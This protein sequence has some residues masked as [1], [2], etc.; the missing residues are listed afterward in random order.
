MLYVTERCVV[1]LR[2]EGLTVVEVAPGVDVARDV[3]Q[4]AGFPLRVAGDLR[5][6][7]ARLFDPAPMGLALPPGRAHGSP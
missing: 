1:E 4:Q 7:D 6:M 5:T 3:L 2:P